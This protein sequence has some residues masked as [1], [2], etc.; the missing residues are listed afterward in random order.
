M[1]TKEKKGIE[2]MGEKMELKMVEIVEK[3][4]LKDGKY[5]WVP[6]EPN[7]VYR[8]TYYRKRI[9]SI[10]ADCLKDGVEIVPIPTEDMGQWTYRYECPRCHRESFEI[11]DIGM[12]M[13]GVI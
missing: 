7:D 12:R 1:E 10:C 8:K 2:E 9:R 5:V 13:D 11:D 3:E 4:I 6:I